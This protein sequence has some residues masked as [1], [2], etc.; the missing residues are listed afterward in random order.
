MDSFV[1]HL[2]MQGAGAFMRQRRA[3]STLSPLDRP[4]WLYTMSRAIYVVEIEMRELYT[5]GVFGLRT[6]T[7]K[8]K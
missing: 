6:E 5:E 7:H 8:G 3:H 4:P 1:G 2:R